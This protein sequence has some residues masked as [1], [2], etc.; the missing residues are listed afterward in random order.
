MGI[1]SEG[2]VNYMALL[3]WSPGSEK[4]VYTIEGLIEDFGLKGLASA[5]AKFDYNRLKWFNLRH[6]QKKSGEELL[7]LLD[8]FGYNTKELSKEKSLQV[9]NA[10]KERSNTL[11]DLWGVCRCFYEAPET[12]DEGGRKK[13][14]TKNTAAVLIGLLEMLE[15]LD[16]EDVER[17][18]ESLELFCEK[19]AE[20]KNPI[21][22]R[23]ILMPFRIALVGSLS[24]LD[25]SFIVSVIGIDETGK[26]LSSFLKTL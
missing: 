3:G 13:A 16:G 25:I 11:K 19:A 1:I 4:E 8:D 14:T 22:Q 15:S 2:L 5:G 12:Y 23:E 7:L 9:L 26:G 24:G 10:A 17:I 6:L 20:G 21:K 18:R